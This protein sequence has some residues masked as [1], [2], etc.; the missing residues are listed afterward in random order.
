MLFAATAISLVQ[1]EQGHVEGRD[2]RR[3]RRC[4]PGFAAIEWLRAVAARAAWPLAWV[5]GLVGDGRR[6]ARSPPAGGSSAT[7]SSA[8]TRTSSPQL[9]LA[10]AVRWAR[11]L[12]DATVA[13]GGI[14]GV[15]NQ[16]PFYG[17]DLS[18]HVQWL[19]IEGEDGAFERIPTCAEWRQALADGGYTHV[20]T[21]YD[22][23]NPGDAHRHQGGAVDA[24]G[25]G[26]RG[27]PA[28]RAGE[29]V[30][31]LRRRPT[32]PPAATCP[33]SAPPSSTATR[34]THDPTAN[35]P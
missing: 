6:S 22:P 12:R 33:T 20:V 1:W 35:Q 17:T 9:K 25:R 16:Y 15:F 26:R 31:A 14:R 19:G 11:D 34:S 4:S 18:N 10:D 32:P 3:G 5:A 29:R 13:V 23:F 24:R 30:R 21:T 27:G 2:R 7:T 28:R 8:A